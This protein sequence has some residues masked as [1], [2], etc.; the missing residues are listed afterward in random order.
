MEALA[1]VPVIRL[2]DQT[3]I[4]ARVGIATGS[5]VVGALIGASG[6]EEGA[7]TG[8][9]PK[10]YALIHADPDQGELLVAAET[11]ET[12]RGAIE[13][14]DRRKTRTKSYKTTVPLPHT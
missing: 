7:V 5:V 3:A 1:A 6:R 14:D 2:A 10:L 13:L 4:S 9:T 8:E 12:L 11:R